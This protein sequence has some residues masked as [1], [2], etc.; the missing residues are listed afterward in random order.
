L[1][2]VVGRAVNVDCAVPDPAISGQHFRLQLERNTV[3]VVDLNSRNHL[4]V[5]DDEVELSPIYDRDVIR[6][7]NTLFRVEFSHEPADTHESAVPDAPP[8]A[9]SPAV[10]RP[11]RTV[12]ITQRLPVLTDLPVPPAN[13]QLYHL[14]EDP[15]GERNTLMK[16]FG[17][18]SK[19]DRTPLRFSDGE[20]FF[21]SNPQRVLF[22]VVD[23]A[24]S[25]EFAFAA[26]RS[27]C[28]PVSLFLGERAWEL[29]EV[30]PYFVRVPFGLPLLLEWC[31]TLGG[32]VG[33]L[34]DSEA[35]P[36]EVFVHLR[37]I[38]IVQDESGQEYFFRY[39]DPRVLNVYLPTCTPDELREFFG[40]IAAWICENASG[41][42]FVAYT[43]DEDGGLATK[44]LGTIQIDETS[45]VVI[46]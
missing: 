44:E 29:V 35:S 45:T 34:I 4:F 1:P 41:D 43:I 10:E 13:W 7:G 39:Y 30:A 46:S 20:D 3:V 6:A 12:A 26:K 16:A 23:A 25:L 40:P 38:F 28:D 18:L 15:H 5:N 14:A 27:G 21:I 8:V 36:E 19:C 22:G 24:Q 33:V 9:G 2:F 31:E 37:G 17:D 32:H 11:D 42:G